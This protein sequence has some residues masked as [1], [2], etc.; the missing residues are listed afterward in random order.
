MSKKL[1]P[2]K[3]IKINCPECG[4]LQ[5]KIYPWSSLTLNPDALVGKC[6]KCMN[7]EVSTL[8]AGVA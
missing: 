7:K 2:E 8:K 5:A 3:I 1:K 6:K 4:E